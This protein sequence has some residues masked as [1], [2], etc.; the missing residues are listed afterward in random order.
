MSRI[1]HATFLS[2]AFRNPKHWK[3]VSFLGHC[4]HFSSQRKIRGAVNMGGAVKTLR[5]SNSLFFYHR[6][7]FVI[8]LVRKSSERANHALVIV[9]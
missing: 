9:L 4:K 2:K 6:N 8:V 5:R 3:Y 1:C 7:S